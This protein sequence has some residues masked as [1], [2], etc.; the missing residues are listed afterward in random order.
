MFVPSLDGTKAKPIWD[1]IKEPLKLLTCNSPQDN[2]FYDS[3]L[4]KLECAL[5]RCKACP[6]SLPVFPG[7]DFRWNSPDITDHEFCIWKFFDG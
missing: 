7:E 6:K 1:T 5:N 2:I 4:F 3:G